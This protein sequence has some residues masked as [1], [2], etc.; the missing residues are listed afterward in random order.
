MKPT[1]MKKMALGLAMGSALAIAPSA[2]AETGTAIGAGNIS[3]NARQDFRVIIPQF[4]I[5]RVG[6]AGA[7]FSLIDCDMSLVAPASIGNGVDQACVGGDV[8]GGVSNV[9]VISNAGNININ[10]NTTG[11]LQNVAADNMPFTEI[12]AVSSDAANL[13]VPL[14]PVSGLG[15]AVNVAPSA[16]A[17]TNRS[18]TWTYT[19]DNSAIY[20]AGTYGGVNVNNGRVTYTAANF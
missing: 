20:P 16:G 8:G 15:V 9:S 3:A 10:V 1:L 4:I 6:V 17:V 2:N 5:F 14:M 18:A 11:Q 13:P 12:V 7:G 19:Y